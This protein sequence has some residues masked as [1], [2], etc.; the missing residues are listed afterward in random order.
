MRQGVNTCG[1][2]ERGAD[3]LLEVFHQLLDNLYSNLKASDLNDTLGA[4]CCWVLHSEIAEY[5]EAAVAADIISTVFI[6]KIAQGML[7]ECH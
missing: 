3:L 1:I 7:K 2:G 6:A 5:F 4:I